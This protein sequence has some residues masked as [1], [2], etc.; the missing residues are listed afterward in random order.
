MASTLRCTRRGEHKVGVLEYT[1][2]SEEE[3][4]ERA[5]R[6]REANRN[7]AASTECTPP[8]SA[9]RPGDPGPLGGCQAGCE[10][11]SKGGRRDLTPGY[12]RERKRPGCGGAPGGI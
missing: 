4:R 3:V 2:M 11:P 10:A 8:P 7:A 5:E 6:Q 9:P 12:K 1:L